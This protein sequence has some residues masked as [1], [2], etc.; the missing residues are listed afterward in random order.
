MQPRLAP[1][2]CITSTGIARSLLSTESRTRTANGTKVISD[3][4]LVMAIERTV[5][6]RTSTAHTPLMPCIR[7]SIVRARRSKIPVDLMPATHAMKQNRMQR[8]LTSTYPVYPLSGGTR[9]I[10]TSIRIRDASRTSLPL[11]RCMSPSI[12]RPCRRRIY[13][14]PS[15]GSV[16]YIYLNGVTSCR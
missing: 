12:R 7:S 2:V 4:S 3:T 5:G 1:T 10:D 16:G 9:T 8:V 11:M 14:G 6:S 13:A 15:V